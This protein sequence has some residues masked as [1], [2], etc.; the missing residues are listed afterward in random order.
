MF[1]RDF[2][3]PARSKASTR[4]PTASSRARPWSDAIAETMVEAIGDAID[5]YPPAPIAAMN[6]SRGFL[7]QR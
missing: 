4:A 1:R 5:A 3:L 6:A 7:E 2:P